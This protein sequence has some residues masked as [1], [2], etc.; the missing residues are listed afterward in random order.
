MASTQ[1]ELVKEGLRRYEEM[2]PPVTRYEE[3]MM[4]RAM[5]MY[6]GE[7]TREEAHEQVMEQLRNEE[8]DE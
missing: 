1:W 3:L 8:N 4:A 7:M 5:S 6:L 2:Q